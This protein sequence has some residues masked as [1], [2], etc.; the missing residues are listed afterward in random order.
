MI[1]M[2]YL[3]ILKYFYCN[4]FLKYN[5][6]NDQDLY[7]NIFNFLN[8]GKVNGKRVWPNYIENIKDKKKRDRKKLDFYRKIGYFRN[9]NSKQGCKTNL[10]NDNFINIKNQ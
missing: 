7:L 4:P 5:A 2:N 8:S 3:N 9:K 6:G 1:Q 10:I